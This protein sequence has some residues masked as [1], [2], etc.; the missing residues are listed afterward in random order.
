M[1]IFVYH[2]T[3]HYTFLLY[4]FRRLTKDCA[5]SIICTKPYVCVSVVTVV[6]AK[7]LVS[8]KEGI[9]RHRI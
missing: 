4:D 5:T 9:G 6:Q 1:W 7:G 3:F 8:V 2:S